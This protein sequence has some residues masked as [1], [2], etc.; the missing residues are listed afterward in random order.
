MITGEYLRRKRRAADLTLESVG[1]SAGRTKQRISAIEKNGAS[2]NI[3]NHIN[4]VIDKLIELG[5]TKK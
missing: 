5:S 1:L 3:L 4:S 2:E